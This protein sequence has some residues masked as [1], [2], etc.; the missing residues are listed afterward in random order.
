MRVWTHNIG[1]LSSKMEELLTAFQ[2]RR[3]DTCALQKSMGY[4]QQLLYRTWTRRK[5]ATA[6]P[7]LL[8]FK[9]NTTSELPSLKVPATT[10]K[11][12]WS[13]DQFFDRLCVKNRSAQYRRKYLLTT[14]RHK[15]SESAYDD[16]I[17]KKT[18][19]KSFGTHN[20]RISSILPILMTWYLR[21][22]SLLDGYFTFF[23]FKVADTT[24]LYFR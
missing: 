18:N 8:A 24:R 5:M 9:F 19:G 4:C 21:I 2:K 23:H 16:Y 6:C 14:T 20:Q 13:Y 7:I 10:L 11:L 22:D 17:G 12:K 1:S 3:I 15:D